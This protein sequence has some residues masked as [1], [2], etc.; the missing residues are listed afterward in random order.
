MVITSRENKIY[1]LAVK[2]KEKRGRDDEGMFLIEGLRSVR[3]AYKKG[4]KFE[5]V[6]ACE[7]TPS[8]DY[9][10]PVTFLAPRLFRELSDTVNPQGIIAVCKITNCSFKNF[11]KK[12]NGCVILC[13][14]V[15]DP[16]NIGTI[17]RTAHAACA[18]GVVLSKGSCDLYNPK[19]VRST[20]S[21]IFSVP[22]VSGVNTNEAIAYFKKNGYKI[23]AGALTEE[24]ENLFTANLKGKYVLIIG[25]EANGVSEETLNLCDSVV[26]IPMQEDAESLNA[27][28]AGG[29]MVYEHFRQNNI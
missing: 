6:F 27:S 15:Q 14:A 5:F 2:L 9:G 22:V 21:A 29:I 16:G 8:E 4:A 28:V 20:M 19:I 18:E 25:N 26:K 17:I 12:E 10:C 11:H 24:S 23:A 7:G 13:E 1:K 3:D